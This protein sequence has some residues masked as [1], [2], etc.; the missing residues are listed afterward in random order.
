MSK[1]IIVLER[2]NIPSDMDFRYV[3]WADVP[4]TRQ[5]YYANPIATSL[6]KDATTVELTA[7][8]TGVVV[9]TSGIWQSVSGQTVSQ[10]KAALITE[11]TRYQNHITNDN[12]IPYY[13]TSYDGTTWTNVTVA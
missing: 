4:T 3:F 13:G 12:P 2:V 10:I 9:E 1:K 11:F 6:Y 5:S 8:Q 7:I